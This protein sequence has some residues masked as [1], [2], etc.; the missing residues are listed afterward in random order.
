MT[1]LAA[2]GGPLPTVANVLAM[3]ALQSGRPLVLAGRDRL[4]RLVRWLHVLELEDITTLLRGG[5]LIL[6]TGIGL[7]DDASR[8]RAYVDALVDAD[9]SGLLI[10]TGR[11]FTEVPEAM[12]RACDRAG[13]PLVQLRRQLPF[14]E[15]TEA[16]HADIVQKQFSALTTL[17]RAHE[18]FTAL[19]IDGAGAEEIVRETAKMVD[20]PVVFEDLMY[21]VLAYDALD[22]P[23]ADLLTN[24]ANRS[25]A[26]RVRQRS[27]FA[28]PEGW[29]VTSVEARGEL[30]GRL[31]VVARDSLTN[32]QLMIAE[33]AA[34]AL[35]LS[36]LLARDGAVLEGRA[37]ASLLSDI[38]ERRYPN[39]RE[40]HV[41]TAAL[42]VPTARRTL[43]GVAVQR[44]DDR[45]RRGGRPYRSSRDADRIAA[46]I[47]TSG[48]PNLASTASDGVVDVLVTLDATADKDAVLTVL[49]E[50]L[51]KP[52]AEAVL[53]G[54][55]SPV[56]SLQD[57]PR[58]FAEARHVLAAARALN[59]RR[60]YFEM[61]DVQLRG[62]LYTLADD[63]RLQAFVERMLGP[64][65]DFD[66]RNDTD[67]VGALRIYLEHRGNKSGA[68]SAAHVSRQ[69][70]YQRLATIERI[71]AVDLESAEVCTSLH[72]ALMG[73]DGDA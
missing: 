32:E 12:I 63:P 45:G 44:Q 4:D 69:S 19:S 33:R 22:V 50:A 30:F 71:L 13:L 64:L 62:L 6:T 41:R 67:L 57:L 47:R 27:G 7:P 40:M 56:P 5:E 52:S 25:R 73:L 59:V 66:S 65:L 8:L 28:E 48:V 21:R 23:L 15:L 60:G 49:A 70:F 35:T 43:L 18:V 34:T 46:M 72:A 9:A 39:E 53:I 42:G 26:V 1:P 38:V 11:R 61:P 17:Q 14:V 20:A 36:R 29:A 51:Q 58:S 3:P 2:M 37:H 54:V 55:G 31:I 68:A 24:W 16:V 10:E